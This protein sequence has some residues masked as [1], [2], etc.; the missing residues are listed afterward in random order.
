MTFVAIDPSET[1]TPV[2]KVRGIGRTRAIASATL[3]SAFVLAA[4]AGAYLLFPA[5]E[6][7]RSETIRIGRIED[8]PE[9]K[10]GVPELA[11]AKPRASA[12]YANDL[13][14]PVERS[15]GSPEQREPAQPQLRASG[16]V[17]AEASSTAFESS[18]PAPS[19][20]GQTHAAPPGGAVAAAQ[21]MV[22]DS[23]DARKTST[24]PI[25]PVAAPAPAQPSAPTV[26][27]SGLENQP[28]PPRLKG[29]PVGPPASDLVAR[30]TAT[31]ALPRQ[32]PAGPEARTHSRK[33]Q[34]E[35]RS[36]QNHAA[37]QR[38]GATP[39]PA[40]HRIRNSTNDPKAEPRKG[41]AAS[42]KPQL[43][44]SSQLQAAGTGVVSG[45][46]VNAEP[47]KAPADGERL[48]VFG[49]PLATAREVKD[50]LLEFRC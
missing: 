18:P 2:P 3:A 6:P 40:T 24:P 35:R 22:I 8:W 49:I 21:P 47:T 32:Q 30:E 29:E 9:I 14:V 34:L 50:C 41:R 43:A 42:S 15:S 37:P 23:P 38:A 19:R 5:A 45:A 13:P 7:H 10:N 26:A 1:R 17:S 16:P 48:R 36:R 27:L 25:L 31:A 44:A 12:D 46:T 28:T 11:P 33:P 4:V 39:A 20:E